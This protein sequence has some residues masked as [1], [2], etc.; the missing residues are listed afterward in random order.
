MQVNPPFCGQNLRGLEI[1]RAVSSAAESGALLTNCEENAASVFGDFPADCGD[2]DVVVHLEDCEVCCLL[3][4]FGRSVAGLHCCGFEEGPRGRFASLPFSA[5]PLR[6]LV[7]DCLTSAFMCFWNDLM[8]TSTW[9]GRCSG[10]WH[11]STL[12]C[13]DDN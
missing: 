9:H 4:R 5:A 1:S 6:L 3:P 13:R 11:L 8:M 10:Q 12:P 2:A 7:C